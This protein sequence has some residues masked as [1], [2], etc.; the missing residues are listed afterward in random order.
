MKSLF[1]AFFILLT[2]PLYAL[3]DFDLAKYGPDDTIEI[4]REGFVVKLVL[5]KFQEKLDE[6]YKKFT[7]QEDSS[8]SGI[9]G[10]AQMSEG[11]DVCYVHI[12]PA[13]IWDDREALT[14]MGHEIYHCALADHKDLIEDTYIEDKGLNSEDLL[15]KDRELELEWLSEDYIEMGIEI[16]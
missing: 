9:R 4:E 5:Y 13:E 10:F 15:S 8:E 11:E 1:L 7:K 3:D 14:I 12:I 2:T 16:D 6:A